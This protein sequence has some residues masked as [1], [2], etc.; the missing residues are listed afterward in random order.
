MV[1]EFEFR[2]VLYPRVMAI[3]I[4]FVR[5]VGK[6]QN[7]PLKKTKRYHGDLCGHKIPMVSR[8]FL[9]ILDGCF[10]LAQ[11]HPTWWSSTWPSH[12]LRSV[13]EPWGTQRKNRYRD[14]HGYYFFS[15]VFHLRF[16]VDVEIYHYDS[17]DIWSTS[18]IDM[19]SGKRLHNYGKIRHLE[20]KHP[21]FQWPF[22][23]ANC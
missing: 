18:N 15:H 6:P 7:R 21:L 19:P 5:T 10:A 1:F 22:S 12:L 4:G 14:R 16:F 3:S 13:D 20:W 9:D 8:C 23:I 2:H 17:W 11:N